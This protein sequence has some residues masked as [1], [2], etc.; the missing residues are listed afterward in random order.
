MYNF[1]PLLTYKTAGIIKKST[2]NEND[3]YSLELNCSQEK[4]HC[5][6]HP[7]KEIELVDFCLEAKRNFN[8]D[9]LFFVNGFQSWSTSPEVHNSDKLK[10]AIGLSN[11]NK[12][13]KHM[14]NISGDGLFTSY[15][16]R[17]VFHS[18]TYTYFRKDNNI[19]LFGSMSE[20]FG[21]TIFEINSN[22]ELFKIRKDVE[23]VIISSDYELADVRIISKEY[24]AAFDDYFASMNLRKPKIKHLSGYT[25]W[26]NYFQNIDEKIIYRDL[27]GL[28][29]V[30]DSAS[31]FQI[32][33][34]YESFVGDWLE[35]DKKKFPA[36][37]K[38]AAD[39]IHEKGF[40][41][42][43]WI[44]P[45]SAQK[46]SKVAAEHPEWLIKDENGKPMLGAVAW[47]GA[48]TLDM[49]NPEAREYIKKFFGVILNEWGYD[50]VKL[51]FLYSEAAYPREGK[52]RGQIMCEAM[53]FL[54]ECVGDEKLILGCGVP[55]GPSFGTVD[56]CRI[57]CD[58]DL[59]Y[60]GKY[61]NKLHVNRE[62]PSAQNSMNNS[63]FRRHLNQRV[64]CND[65]DVFFLRRKN[66]DFT[67][68]QKYILGRVNNL[69]GDILFVSDDI[70]EYGE[71]E[72]ELLKELFAENDV[73]IVSAGYTEKNIMTLKYIKN[74]KQNVFSFNMKK[75]VVIK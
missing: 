13:A 21:Y 19:E 36:G 30:K 4:V 67:D 23:G 18:F 16:E 32:D 8:D 42:G 54:R 27:D 64:F 47:N 57:S 39:K 62:L 68:E 74:G 50:M 37:M 2:E 71:R 34:G 73:K 31:I 7:K 5:V 53:E 45:F 65:P 46:K 48:Y 10:G 70:A 49:Y 41:A 29:K 14:A 15:G 17:G 38:E 66:L 63:I 20:K 56:A 6:I 1:K 26:Y 69:C 12:A 75:G 59:V 28:E 9:E 40:K 25:S 35:V 60:D 55:L 58:V 24:D 33:D 22:A 51:D 52:S 61:Y 44:A 43:I 72:L 11:I 3:D